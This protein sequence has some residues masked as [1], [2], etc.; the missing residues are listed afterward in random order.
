MDPDGRTPRP[1]YN[2]VNSDEWSVLWARVKAV[3]ARQ[4]L[5]D[6]GAASK[7]AEVADDKS[8]EHFQYSLDNSPQNAF[9]HA[10]WACLM[11]CV[12]DPEFAMT[13]LTAHETGD[14]NGKPGG[15]LMDLRNNVLGV[16]L[17]SDPQTCEHNGCFQMVDE[18]QK[19]GQLTDQP[20][21][22]IKEQKKRIRFDNLG[23]DDWNVID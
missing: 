16:R 19:S 6:I 15:T 18:A 20:V 4:V 14:E 3:G 12:I 13:Y 5:E 7:A 10:Y 17:G 2:D 11:S 8:T 22:P 1:T 9:K 21:A 23:T